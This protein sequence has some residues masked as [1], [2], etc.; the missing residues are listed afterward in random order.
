MELKRGYQFRY[1]NN[2]WKVT[3]VY[4]ISW[5]D[6]TKST[7]YQIKSKH[8]VAYLEVH[9]NKDKE[10]LY[11]FWVKDVNKERFLLK[12]S[13]PKSDY[14]S[15]GKANFPRKIYHAGVEYNFHER[16]DGI[17][18][19]GYDDERVNSLDYENADFTKKLAIELWDDEIE[20][21][22]GIPILA[23]DISHIEKK[24]SYINTNAIVNT[25]ENNISFFYLLAF[26]ILFIVIV[27][28]S[29]EN[30][31]N[32]VYRN[33]GSFYRGRSSSGFGK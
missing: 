1:N 21:S 22:T 8:R 7:E 3:E 13:N 27:R 2:T 31:S 15:L 30:N 14:I 23:E 10:T 25:I 28:C 18:Y 12:I 26:V 33:S 9:L 19:Y 17:C 4:N 20:I 29:E 5:D 6:G 24:R 11:S 32:T 16:T